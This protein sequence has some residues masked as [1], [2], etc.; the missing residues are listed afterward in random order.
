MTTAYVYKWTHI[1]SLRWYVGSRVATGCH[2]DDGYICNSKDVKPMIVN[3]PTEWKREIIDTGSQEEMYQ[4]ETDILRLFDA[5]ND[6]MSFNKHNND[7]IYVSWGDKHPNK[8][9][10]N[11]KKIS[12]GLK[13]VPK[14][15]THNE[16]VSKSLIALGDAHPSR[17]KD[18]RDS[19]RK[20][21]LAK[22][23]EHHQKTD[24]ARAE[25]SSRV[26]GDKN[27]MFGVHGEKHHLFGKPAHPN[28]VK[29]GSS[30]P[31]S[32]AVHTPLGVFET[33]VA[34]AA[35]HT[36]SYSTIRNWANSDKDEHKDYYFI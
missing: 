4:L 7:G 23:D 2:P 36:V 18:V 20:K 1:P 13:G 25:A 29:H 22:G 15:K 5:K 10:I 17:R 26:S 33:L 8:N 16:R 12:I 21:M 3:S 32:K 30:N 9:P 14:S 24:E 31:Q 35:V 34:A 28:S 27:P 19:K 6:P 11:A